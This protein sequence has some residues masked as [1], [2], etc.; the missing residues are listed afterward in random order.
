MGHGY[1]RGCIYSPF[2]FLNACKKYPC[3]G[4]LKEKGFS[5]F[6]KMKIMKKII[7]FIISILFIGAITKAQVPKEIVEK[8]WGAYRSSLQTLQRAVKFSSGKR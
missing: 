5:I 4:I 8:S 6:I 3:K 7:L 1:K 2:S